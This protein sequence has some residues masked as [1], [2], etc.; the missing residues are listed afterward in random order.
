MNRL[1]SWNPTDNENRKLLEHLRNERDA[2][3]TFLHDPKVPASNYWGEQAIRPAVVTRKV[4]GGNRTARGAHTQ[5]TL[6]SFLR[7][8]DQQA[9]A[10]GSLIVLVL[11][12]PVPLVAP[13]PCFDLGP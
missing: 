11:C 10:S 1:L 12:S 8:C 4:W 2:L 9:V 5:G 6:A 3:F 13:L 7:S